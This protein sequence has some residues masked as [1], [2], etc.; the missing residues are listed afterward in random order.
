EFYGSQGTLVTN[1]RGWTVYEG[2]GKNEK[3]AR[4]VEPKVDQQ[5]AHQQNFLDCIV[6]REKP[7]ADI[8][9]GYRSTLLCLLANIAWR[10]RSVLHSDKATES[11]LGNE[12]AA[13][14]MGRTYRKGF[15]LPEIV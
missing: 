4:Q 2:T 15:E 9:I 13:R 11:I 5:R 3:V 1:G 10:T 8:E 12:P 14:L 6:S 7:N